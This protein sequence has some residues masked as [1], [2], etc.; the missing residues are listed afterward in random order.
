MAM[1]KEQMAAQIEAWRAQI[2]AYDET[3]ATAPINPYLPVIVQL[4]D[5]L[6]ALTNATAFLG[7]G[8]KAPSRISG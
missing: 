7:G 4:Y 8:I 1:T 5:D 6:Q 3:T 2:E